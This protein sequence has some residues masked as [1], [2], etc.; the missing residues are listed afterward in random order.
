MGFEANEVRTS[1]NINRKESKPTP[2]ISTNL[3]SHL[4]TVRDIYYT[5]DLKFL[6]SVGDDKIINVW[7][8]KKSLHNSREVYDPYL[9]L[10]GHTDKIISISGHEDKK[11]NNNSYTFYTAGVDV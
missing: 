8:L 4:D 10:R 7:D 1:L 3:K 9:S 5:P 11:L 6:L 2:T